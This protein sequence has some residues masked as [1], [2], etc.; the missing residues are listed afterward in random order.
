M[1]LDEFKGDFSYKNWDLRMQ[2]FDPL[3]NVGDIRHAVVM[4]CILP[5]GVEEM[6]KPKSVLIAG[7]RQSGKHILANAIFTATNCV[8][9]DLSM[10]NMVGKYPGKK[11]CK[12]ITQ[13]FSLFL[14]I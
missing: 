8:L 3:Q 5:L 12:K 13:L 4:N 11:V 6:K 9:F 10:R 1:F 2:H 14:I 7:P